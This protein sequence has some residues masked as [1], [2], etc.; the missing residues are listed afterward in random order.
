MGFSGP[1]TSFDPE[2]AQKCDACQKRLQDKRAP[3]CVEACATGALMFEEAGEFLDSR[4]QAVALDISLAMAG[5][6]AGHIPENVVL[7]KKINQRLARLGPLPS[8]E[9]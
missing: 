1:E 4:Q 3:A 9:I 7:F 5:A 8:S 6:G 2:K